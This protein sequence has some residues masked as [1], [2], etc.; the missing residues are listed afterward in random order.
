MLILSV[1]LI[2]KSPN[3][4]IKISLAYSKNDQQPVTGLN[5]VEEINISASDLKS[6]IGSLVEIKNLHCVEEEA[7][8]INKF[9]ENGNAPLAG[10]G[11]T[12]SS[13]AHENDLNPYLVAA[14]GWC[15]SN[16]GKV[17]PQFGEKESY[18]AWGWAVLDSNSNTRELG[19]YGCDSWEHCIGRVTRGIA[20]KS[21]QGKEPVDIVKWYTPASVRKADGIAE[22]AP[23]VKCVNVTI[24]KIENLPL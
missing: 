1:Y 20:K 8:K 10:Y 12:F 22:N 13:Q 14:I 4:G 3:L 15:E 24:D 16:G 2:S 5:Y 21:N 19:A 18:N 9:F 17:T 11:C 6:E 23:W 7:S